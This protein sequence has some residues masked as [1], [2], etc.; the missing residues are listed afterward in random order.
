MQ[1]SGPPPIA[2]IADA[3]FH[4]LSADYGI[5]GLGVGEPKRVLRSFADMVKSTRV[6]NEAD[7]ALRYA[8]D[9]IVARGIRHVVLLG[10]YSDD[11]QVETLSGL[12]A[13][14]E[15]YSES[16]GLRFFATP[17]NHDIFG[18]HGRHRRKRLLNRDLASDLVTSNPEQRAGP[19]DAAVFVADGMRCPGYP[20]G[21]R[22]LPAVG[23]FRGPGYLHWETPFGPDDMPEARL[24]GVRSADGQVTHALMDASYLVEPVAGVWLLMVDANVFVPLNGAPRDGEEAF[25]DSTDAGWNAML[26]HKRFILGWMGD[27]A[28]RANTLGKTL[29]AFSHYPALDPLDRTRDDELAVLGETSLSRRIPKP[30]VGAALIQAGIRV[31]VSGHLH[32]NDTSRLTSA[33]GFLVNVSVPSLVAFPAAYKVL[34]IDAGRLHVDTV[35]IGA[36]KLDREITGLYRAEAGKAG[37]EADGLLAAG[38]YGTFLSA[39]LGHLVGRRHLRR[40]WPPELARAAVALD[41]HDLA[42]LALIDRPLAPGGLAEEMRRLRRAPDARERLKALLDAQKLD[43]DMLSG[44]PLMTF[45]GAWYRVKMGSDLGL[46]AITPGNLAIYRSLS[47]LYAAKTWQDGTLQAAFARLLRMFDRFTSGLPSRDFSIDLC[48]GDIQ[49]R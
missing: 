19:R 43:A 49:G 25:A 29:I 23:F 46:D 35:G 10:D 38:D 24:Y 30:D 6:F 45:L 3:H 2:V 34:R 1:S 41:L 14:L 22:M 4:D 17:G 18:P 11:G 47:A 9:D 5:D 42:A 21:L 31:H 32:V 7:N 33:G 26:V 40:E 44:I 37:I 36:M 27:V 16:H 13:L 48:T 20:E 28:A 15:Y 12:S 8:L 39:H